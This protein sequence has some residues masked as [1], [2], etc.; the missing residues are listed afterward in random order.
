MFYQKNQGFD[1]VH[2]S[3]ILVFKSQSKIDFSFMDSC[4]LGFIPEMVGQKEK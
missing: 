3:L 2:L 4:Y 1:F